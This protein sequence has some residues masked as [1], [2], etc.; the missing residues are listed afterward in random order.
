MH[1]DFPWRMDQARLEESSGR[2]LNPL[3]PTD[4]QQLRYDAPPLCPGTEK[5]RVS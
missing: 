1:H 4:T 3:P 2:P 5:S